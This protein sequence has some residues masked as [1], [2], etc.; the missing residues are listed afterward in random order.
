MQFQVNFAHLHLL[1][2]HIPVIGS[3]IGFCLFFI[4]FFGKNEDLQASA[5][6]SFLLLALLC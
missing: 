6:S 2:N 4:S 5:A 1:L 3:I